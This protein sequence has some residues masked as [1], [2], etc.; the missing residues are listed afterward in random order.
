MNSRA[1]FIPQIVAILMLLWA[2]NPENPY[3]YYVLLRIVLCGICAFLAYRALKIGNEK[4]AW[5]LGVTAVIYNPIIPIH[6]TR[7]IWSVVK[8]GKEENFM[9]ISAVS[10]ITGIEVYTLRYWEREF[11]EYLNPPRTPGGQRRYRPNDIQKVFTLKR[12]LREQMFSIAGVYKVN[13]DTYQID[14][15]E[16]AA[17][18]GAEYKKYVIGANVKPMAGFDVSAE[19]VRHITKASAS[20]DNVKQDTW[21]VGALYATGK[22]AV[23]L[24]YAKIKDNDTAT[25]DTGANAINLAYKYNLSKQTMFLANIGRVKNDN[26]AR[27]GGSSS[28]ASN[29][30]FVVSAGN[31][32]GTGS[33][34]TVVAAGLRTDF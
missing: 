30:P 4:W 24:Q 7:E 15:G 17:V 12:L 13:K 3:G 28:S 22:H 10:K 6:L 33:E 34:I 9:S 1:R 23:A 21:G 8:A 25:T 16:A 5:I 11:M 18:T 32:G 19:W 27:F 26:N 29:A 20:A 14:D 31:L 2:L